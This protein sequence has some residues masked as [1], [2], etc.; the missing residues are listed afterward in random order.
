M[1][2]L[3]NPETLRKGIGLFSTFILSLLI[4]LTVLLVILNMSLF[5]GY[6]FNQAMKQTDYV[7]RNY[8]ALNE[9]VTLRLKQYGIDAIVLDGL[10]N[11]EMFEND[12]R[13][14]F[15]S[16]F[17]QEELSIDYSNITNEL[18]TRLKAF[19]IEQDLT[20]TKEV[21]TGLLEIEA[22]V[23]EAYRA[24]TAFPF[25]NTYLIV[26][27]PFKDLFLPIV[28]IG[29]VL[30]GLLIY[31]LK[32]LLSPNQFLSNLTVAFASCGWM[33]VLAPA[34]LYIEGFYKRINLEPEVLKNFIEV[35]LGNLFLNSMIV[36]IGILFI[37]FFFNL[38]RNSKR[39]NS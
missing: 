1:N 35:L 39:K 15:D 18:D 26:Y 24:H 25:R 23:L 7:H 5:S 29:L 19:I 17:K 32:R 21:E 3:R 33:L 13:D 9:T 36:G 20:L 14:Q 16:V 27:K 4:T 11:P 30:S 34:Y 8:L 10:F 6:G 22:I 12:L 38:F 31:F 2:Q 37:L 28:G